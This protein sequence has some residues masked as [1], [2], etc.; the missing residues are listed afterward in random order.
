MFYEAEYAISHYMG[1]LILRWPDD[2]SPL[3]GTPGLPRIQLTDEDLTVDHGY[4]VLNEL[5]LARVVTEIEQHHAIGSCSAPEE[6]GDQ[7][8]GGS[9]RCRTF[10]DSAAELA[11]SSSRAVR[12]RRRWL[13][14]LRG[15]RLRRICTCWTRP[16]PQQRAPRTGFGAR[17]CRTSLTG[18]TVRVARV[19]RG[20]PCRV[21]RPGERGR[22]AVACVS[23]STVPGVSSIPM[24][25]TSQPLAGRSVFLSSGIPN[26]TQWSGGFE[27]MEI[28]HAVVACAR[29]VLS[30]GGT[31][32]T[33]AH[34]TIAPLLLY[35]A[36]EFPKDPTQPPSIII[37][38]SW[39][40]QDRLPQETY[41]MAEGGLADVRWTAAADDGRADQRD[42]WGTSLAIMRTE[43]F[44][45]N[46]LVAAVFIGGM[47]VSR[48]NST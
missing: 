37:Y 31:L 18:V 44:Q 45:N 16:P 21:A 40:F 24:R 8:P 7:C 43:M 48:R 42:T 32:R 47:K 11:V 13:G 12:Q 3:P 1:V 14:S 4:Q 15:Y 30:F 29:A 6:H 17:A 25:N 5:A 10:G 26:R 33:A 41:D 22:N 39:L 46:D 2:P 34:P 28:A 27:P 20:R 38:Q 9:G 35:L 36:R 19:V 23:E